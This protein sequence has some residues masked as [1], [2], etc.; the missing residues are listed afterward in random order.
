MSSRTQEG[1]PGVQGGDQHAVS[2]LLPSARLRARKLDASGVDIS[3]VVAAFNQE[4]ARAFERLVALGVVEASARVNL[5]VLGLACR[6]EHEPSLSVSDGLKL[7]ELEPARNF[8]KGL[9]RWRIRLQ[10]AAQLEPAPVAQEGRVLRP[11]AGRLRTPSDWR[12]DPLAPSCEQAMVWHRSQRGRCVTSQREASVWSSVSRAVSVL[13]DFVGD[14]GCVVRA[15]NS[16]ASTVAGSL[17]SGHPY[18]SV[19]FM[20]S[21]P[22]ELVWQDVRCSST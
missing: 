6:L 10:E 14:G 19:H 20:R 1:G 8:C 2:R 15:D 9:G 17:L 21:A 5:T 7:A 13:Q 12:L 18:F 4:G 3:P 11:A 22:S 16:M